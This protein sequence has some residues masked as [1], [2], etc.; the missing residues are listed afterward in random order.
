MINYAG[1]I[2]LV[3][4]TFSEPYNLHIYSSWIFRLRDVRPAENES[5]LDDVKVEVTYR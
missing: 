5:L 1:E 3:R 4:Q 2:K